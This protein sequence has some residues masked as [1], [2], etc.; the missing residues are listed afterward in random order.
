MH[1]GVFQ[2]L[3]DIKPDV[4]L[5]HGLCG[6]ELRTV[7][8]YKRL[9]PTVRL[10]VD[11][12]EDSNNSARTF[13]SNYILHR[14]YY[15]WIIRQCMRSVDK[16]L[17]ISVDVMSFVQRMYG[18]PLELLEFYPLGGE[19]FSDAEYA[20]RRARGRFE[21]GLQD[22]QV[23]VLQTGKMGRRKKVLES[24]SAFSNTQGDNLR[25]VLAGSFEDD[26][27][28]DALSR[29]ARDARIIFLGWKT[30]EQLK[31]LLCAADIYI[32]P[33]TQ[34]A[35]MQMSLCARCPVV[36]DDVPSHRPFVE[37]NG[38]LI[39]H[40]DE[41]P[42]VFELIR[43]EPVALGRMSGKSLEIAKR[44]LDYRALAARIC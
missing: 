1:P 27:K 22:D 8:R 18:I 35:T 13:L 32:Q 24:L 21:L 2:L 43:D 3:C 33:G 37:G 30:T 11:S 34:S 14:L 28:S 12:H 42:Q 36:L 40:V 41:L 25:L 19:V 39:K 20:E 6:W 23:M 10:Y 31:S 16:I 29:V 17:C 44:H 38:W 5:F 26:I 4:I 15:A 7:V 9:N